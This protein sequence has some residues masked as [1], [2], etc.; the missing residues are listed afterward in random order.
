[1]DLFNRIHI[2]LFST[3][4]VYLHWE[5]EENGY[6]FQN[7]CEK[8][9]IRALLAETRSSTTM[10]SS[11][12]PASHR[13]G[14]LRQSGLEPRPIHHDSI[15]SPWTN[16]QWRL[17]RN[18]QERTGF[19]TIRTSPYQ[20]DTLNRVISAASVLRTASPTRLIGRLLLALLPLVPAE[21]EPSCYVRTTSRSTRR[22]FCRGAVSTST[23]VNIQKLRPLGARE[24]SV[25]EAALPALVALVAGVISIARAAAADDLAARAV[26]AAAAL[27]GEATDTRPP[28]PRSH[29]VLPKP[30][31]SRFPSPTRFP[32]R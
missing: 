7:L 31:R 6:S 9:C 14:I 25:L 32:S 27:P 29:R 23:V 26:Y 12:L 28:T 11:P 17:S 8:R 13:R 19:V 21:H 24:L 18:F 5:T 4:L 3:R 22:G 16:E 15:I 1:M 30:M 20:S 10:R 2:L